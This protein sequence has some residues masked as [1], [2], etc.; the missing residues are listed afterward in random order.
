MS[1]LPI[2]QE[3]AITPK[4]IE[5]G[6]KVLSTSGLA[7]EY[8]GADRLLVAEIYRAMELVAFQDK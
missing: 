1:K 5:A 2:S 8:L 6:F 4:M 7:D 3:I